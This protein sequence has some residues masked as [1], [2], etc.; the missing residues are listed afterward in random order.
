MLY[1][2]SMVILSTLY[3]N[4]TE[5]QQHSS[6]KASRDTAHTIDCGSLA[7]ACWL[8][9]VLSNLPGVGHDACSGLN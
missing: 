5:K 3:N 8:D 4:M 1:C 6:R 9:V 2:C 7:L